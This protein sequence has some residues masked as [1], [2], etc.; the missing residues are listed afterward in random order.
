M[1]VSAS[2]KHLLSDSAVRA[3]EESLSNAIKQPITVRAEIGEVIDTPAAVQKAINN[4]RQE[5]AVKTINE[6]SGV[7]DICQ[8]FSGSVLRDTIRPR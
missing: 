2:Q 1:I 7:S 5:H 6:D 4:M 3:I 8:A